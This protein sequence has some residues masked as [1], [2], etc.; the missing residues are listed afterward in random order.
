MHLS[1]SP[2]EALNE[3]SILRMCLCT[4]MVVMLRNVNLC[5]RASLKH[6]L[7]VR[8]LMEDEVGGGGV[9]GLSAKFKVQVQLLT[10]SRPHSQTLTWSKREKDEKQRQESGEKRQ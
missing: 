1:N 2:E 5:S 4:Y 10:C 6:A 9:W 7:H 3:G 8:T